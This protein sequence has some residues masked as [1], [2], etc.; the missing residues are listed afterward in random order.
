MYS[1]RCHACYQNNP[2][3]I[4]FCFSYR[5]EWSR[6]INSHMLKWAARICALIWQRRGIR[7][8]QSQYHGPC[9][10]RVV[11]VRLWL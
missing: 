4:F 1:S 5:T 3:F 11:S 6:Q 8:Q 7:I 9:K 10:R 2:S